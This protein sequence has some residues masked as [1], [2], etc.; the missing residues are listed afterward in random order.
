M[1]EVLE[2]GWKPDIPEWLFP[3]MR[4]LISYCLQMKFQRR[5]SFD[6]IFDRMKEMNFK[7]I[8]GVNSSKAAKFVKEIESLESVQTDD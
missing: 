1:R 8:A 5:P 4:E 7:V 6:D 2:K 3:E